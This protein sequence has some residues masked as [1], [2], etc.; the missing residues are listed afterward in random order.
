V[1]GFNGFLF[2]S[3]EIGGGHT[4]LPLPLSVRSLVLYYSFAHP[5]PHRIRLA[6]AIRVP[7]GIYG[8][9]ARDGR[10]HFGRTARPWRAQQPTAPP[11]GSSI[12]DSSQQQAVGL[13]VFVSQNENA[14]S[15]VQIHYAPLLSS[16][17]IYWASLPL[18]FFGCS[19]GLRCS[20][21]SLRKGI[22]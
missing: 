21:G 13:R 1:P 15:L 3:S 14:L 5:I 18:L 2:A 22:G 17:K 11:R 6:I 8:H 10:W 16:F 7:Y 20:G 9:F 4:P 19:E 12:V